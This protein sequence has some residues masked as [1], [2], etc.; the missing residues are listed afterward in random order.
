MKWRP[1]NWKE[2]HPNPCIGC[3][4]KVR[5]G[6]GDLTSAQFCL[7]QCGEDHDYNFFEAGADA[8]IEALKVTGQEIT[9]LE[10]AYEVLWFG[11]PHG[12]INLLGDYGTLIFIKHEE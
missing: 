4:D 7:N 10:T 1:D 6:L 3:E 11:C 12:V 9:P 2:I 8:I 5:P